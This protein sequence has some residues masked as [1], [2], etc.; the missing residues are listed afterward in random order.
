MSGPTAFQPSA[1]QA[2]AFQT[3]VPLT[4]AASYSL[5]A[6]QIAIPS[7][8]VKRVLS[9]N[10]YSL[11]SPA[12]AA[13]PLKAVVIFAAPAA[14]SLGSPSFAKP[15]LFSWTR[16]VG[17]DYSLG[18]PSFATPAMGY[19]HVLSKP[20]DYS[21]GSPSFAT[22]ILKIIGY[23]LHANPYSLGSPSFATPGIR[24]IQ[25]LRVNAY[26]IGSPSF[27]TP[28][29]TQR[30]RFFTNAM[31]VGALS[32]STPSVQTNYKLT[33]SP[34]A[35]SGL[36]IAS[37]P[38]VLEITTL[39]RANAY[40]LG[41]P[42]FGFPR[43]QS[44]AVLPAWP[45]TYLTQVESATDMLV[46][47]LNLVLQSIPDN[48]APNANTLLQLVGSL[49]ANAAAAIGGNTLGTQLQQIMLAANIAGATYAGIEE[50]R[51][52]L[53]GFGDSDSYYTQ[54]VMRACLTMT[55]SL[56]SLLITNLTFTTQADAKAMINQVTKMFA[57]AQALGL[58]TVDAL[59]YENLI[60]ISGALT[61]HLA[62][63]ALQLP[64]FLTYRTGMS[65]PSLY[66]A[67]RIYGDASRFEE[68]E[69]E[70]GVVNPAF[71]QREI[72]VLS[73]AGINPLPGGPYR[74][75]AI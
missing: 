53:M 3:S 21:L 62:T 26:S 8:T 74:R 64:R 68:I 19:K 47:F 39:F 22:P 54:I 71:V 69:Q 43:L 37:D 24:Y 1:F 34:F 20:A 52:Y 45:P 36:D 44:Q 16:I 31:A 42:T 27:A 30:H 40:W 7:L 28:Q 11:G 33:T 14:Y 2:N 73:D 6:L 35:I 23:A 9:A 51:K 55:L 38:P 4:V 59:I 56:E 13:P 25:K 61:N 67:N 58:D 72:R 57:D 49:R 12:F 70:N 5:G 65:M 17:G 63:T 48:S 32:F 10:S 41:S 29:F 75:P 18:S 46:G 15:A 50:C 66:L 60:G